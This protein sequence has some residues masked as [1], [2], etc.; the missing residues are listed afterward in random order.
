MS[1]IA[2]SSRTSSSARA[3]D[4]LALTPAERV[5]NPRP[6]PIPRS[7]LLRRRIVYWWNRLKAIG[8]RRRFAEFG[9]GSRIGPNFRVH[10]ASRIAI[11]SDVAIW[12][13]VRIE[14]VGGEDDEIVLRI[15]PGCV[16][17]SYSRIAAAWSVHLGSGVG[18][19]Q[20]VLITDHNHDFRDLTEPW[21]NRPALLARPVEI[22]DGAFVGDGCV[23]LPGVT[24][25]HHSVIGANS[26]VTKDVPPYHVAAGVPARLLSRFDPVTKA[27]HKL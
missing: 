23:I 10:N 19:G 27:W 26:V 21:L 16:I 22:A 4:G 2:P 12:S 18:L 6:R 11:A 8:W 15:G 24:I 3:G 20:G 1:S 9:M 14:A 17:S 7:I 5:I 25:G 13:N